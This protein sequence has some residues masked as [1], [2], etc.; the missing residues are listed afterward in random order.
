MIYTQRLLSAELV[1]I[2]SVLACAAV[3]GAELVPERLDVSLDTTQTL[4]SPSGQVMAD[5][6]QRVSENLLHGATTVTDL[7]LPGRANLDALAYDGDD[8]L[9]SVDTTV[10]LGGWVAAPGDLVRLSGGVPSLELDASAWGVPPG[11]NLDA[12]ARVPNQTLPAGLLFS[13]DI[14]VELPASGG[15]TLVADDEDVVAFDGS[16]FLLVLDGSQE[17]LPT[18]VDLDGLDYHLELPNYDFP[19]LYVSFDISGVVLGLGFDDEDVLAFEPSHDVW[20][21]A[22][23]TSERRPEL[24]R[25]VDVDALEVHLVESNLFLDGLESGDTSAWSA[26]VGN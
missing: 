18:G 22:F 13:Y 2:V 16:H 21:V 11:A 17:G 4:S 23:D 20:Y 7:G 1:L 26:T 25:G 5:D 10:D 15:G 12:V 14:T 8:I 9:F 19:G 3:A 24:D 6:E